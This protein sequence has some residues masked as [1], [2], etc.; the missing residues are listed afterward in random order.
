MMV[1]GLTGGIGTGKSTAAAYLAGKGFAHIDA[2]QIGRDLTADGQPV[3]ETIRDMFGCVSAGTGN[4]LVLDRKAL[5][6]VVFGDSEKRRAFDAVIHREIIA[7][8]DRLIAEYGKMS[9]YRA[10][11]LDAPLLFEAGI[12][13]R[14]DVVILITAD[15]DIRI[16]RV[17]SRDGITPDAVR[18]RIA[19]QMSDE[20]KIKQSDVIV[21]NSGVPE[22]M[23]RQLDEIIKHLEI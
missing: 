5:A 10:V 21:D 16:S 13:D 12:N 23:Y 22:Q 18:A 17:V 1:I 7:E 9:E 19:N 6:D 4:G 3:L 15:M 8:I 11:L 20:E 2:D 14:C